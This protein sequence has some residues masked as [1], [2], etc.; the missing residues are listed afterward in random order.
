[1]PEADKPITQLLTPYFY[2]GCSFR[3]I[4]DDYSSLF[5]YGLLWQ[6]NFTTGDNNSSSESGSTEEIVPY[7]GLISPPGASSL[8]TSTFGSIINRPTPVDTLLQSYDFSVETLC[9][10]YTFFILP[11]SISSTNHTGWA[12]ALLKK[13]GKWD[14]VFY[15]YHLYPSL[16]IDVNDF[17]MGDLDDYARTCDGYLRC[18][19]THATPRRNAPS[20]YYDYAVSYFAIDEIPQI[21]KPQ[22]TS[23]VTYSSTNPYA[24]TITISMKNLEGATAVIAEIL[25][26]GETNPRRIDLLDFRKGHFQVTVDR[27]YYSDITVVA[28]N[29]NGST[30]SA[31]IHVPAESAANSPISPFKA[32]LT[33]H[34]ITIV[35]EAIEILDRQS[36]IEYQILPIMETGP[37]ALVGRLTSTK[38]SINIEDLTPGLYVLLYSD[39][40]GR[41]GTL[42]FRR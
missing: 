22:I 28:Y 4:A 37:T 33:G 14:P 13:D 32:S 15:A 29:D 8:T 36:S 11:D 3:D 1:M 41:Q 19:V 20:G 7:K 30:R 27:E 24:K 25:D 39:S 9:K 23:E 35:P 38:E 2:K 21:I 42:K 10:P 26:E 5:F 6:P 34:E 40:R 31:T 17:Q 12:A 16:T 18:R